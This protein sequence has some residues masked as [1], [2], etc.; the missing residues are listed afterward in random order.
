MD[1][2][3]LADVEDASVAEHLSSARA[4]FDVVATVEMEQASDSKF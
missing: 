3:A 4:L 2:L 1:V